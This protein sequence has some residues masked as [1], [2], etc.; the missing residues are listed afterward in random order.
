MERVRLLLVHGRTKRQQCLTQLVQGQGF[1]VT[2]SEIP[3]TPSTEYMAVIFAGGSIPAGS[4]REV[5]MWSRR[6]IH[7]LNV[8]FLGI[9]LGHLM[10]GLAYGATYRTI[11]S[12]EYGPTSISFRE[13]YPLAPSVRELRVWEDHS[14]TL[15]HLPPQLRNYASSPN[16]KVQAIKH[17]EKDLFGVQFHPEAEEEAGGLIVLENFL[18]MVRRP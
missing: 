13:D 4:Y 3:A 6:F 1:E 18:R 16:T 10:L 14:H 9:C 12:A 17:V 15:V 7:G 8:P 2:V 11:P 5:K